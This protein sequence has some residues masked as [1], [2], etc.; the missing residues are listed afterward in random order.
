MMSVGENVYVDS[1]CEQK[2]QKMLCSTDQNPAA[3]VR[4]SMLMLPVLQHSLRAVGSDGMPQTLVHKGP[5]VEALTLPHHKA[6][7]VHRSALA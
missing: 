7:R 2:C 6:L 4:R 1:K 5:A 3:S